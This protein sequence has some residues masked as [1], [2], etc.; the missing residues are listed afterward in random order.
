MFLIVSSS[1]TASLHK[2]LF[3]MCA[4]DDTRLWANFI[5]WVVVY[6]RVSFLLKPKWGGTKAWKIIL[7]RGRTSLPGSVLMHIISWCMLLYRLLIELL[8]N[9]CWFRFPTIQPDYWIVNVQKIL[10][11][12]CVRQQQWLKIARFEQ[13]CSEKK[14]ILMMIQLKQPKWLVYIAF[15][16][17]HLSA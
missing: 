11:T 8:M 5:P 15:S 7:W 2:T 17:H 10:I 1:L 9:S 16:I 3:W 12:A 13:Y 14:T 4:L 6:V